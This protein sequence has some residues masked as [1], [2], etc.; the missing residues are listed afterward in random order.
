MS[1]VRRW[2]M[3][4]DIVTRLREIPATIEALGAEWVNELDAARLSLEAADEI[5]R[6]REWNI[7]ITKLIQQ[8]QKCMDIW[9]KSEDELIE[10]HH[11]KC[12]EQF[13]E[14]QNEIERLRK[15][16]NYY[17]EMASHI[18]GKNFDANEEIHR[19]KIKLKTVR[20]E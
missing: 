10:V 12:A 17:E 16:R 20:G 4:D 18:A 14:Q 1:T 6:L 19:L 3:T 11:S 15:E 7:E 13:A 5:E 2:A 8:A 9:Q